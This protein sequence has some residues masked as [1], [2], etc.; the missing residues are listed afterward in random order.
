MVF[1]PAGGHFL[2]GGIGQTVK[3][4]LLLLFLFEFFRVDLKSFVQ[5]L[6]ESFATRL[7]ILHLAPG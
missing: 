5:E 7:E 2:F 4:N 6:L 1:S 3:Q